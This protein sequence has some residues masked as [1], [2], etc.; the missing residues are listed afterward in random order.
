MQ[1]KVEYIHPFFILL[2]A[3]FHLR[4]FRYAPD[5]VVFLAAVNKFFEEHLILRN[6]SKSISFSFDI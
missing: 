3:D 6:F 2:T 4:V 1:Q 5:R